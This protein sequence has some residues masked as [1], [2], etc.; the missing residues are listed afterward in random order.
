[1]EWQTEAT[2]VNAQSFY[3]ATLGVTTFDGKVDYRLQREAIERAAID[4]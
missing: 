4:S 2:N 3:A 1:M